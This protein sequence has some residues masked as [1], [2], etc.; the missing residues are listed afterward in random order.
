MK[1]LSLVAKISSAV[2]LFILMLVLA[3]SVPVFRRLE[4]VLDNY[5]QK[6]SQ[7]VTKYS[8]LTISY[9]SISPSIFAYLG[10]KGIKVCD[11]DQRIIGQ[12]KSTHIKYKLIPLLKGDYES[13]VKSITIDGVVL[14]TVPLI[15]FIQAYVVE[16]PP[17]S[18]SE[19]VKKPPALDELFEQLNLLID[20]IPQN[21]TL[22]NFTV[23]YNKDSIN[24]SLLV[25]EIRVLNSERRDYITVSLKSD[26]DAS[27]GAKAS[28]NGALA[29]NGR[30]TRN[31]D[32]S[33]AYIN[34]SNFAF[35]K[36]KFNKFNFLV[37]YAS[38][39]LELH[40][41]QNVIPVDLGADFDFATGQLGLKLV[42]EN[43]SPVSVISNATSQK[44][45]QKFKELSV[46]ARAGLDL[47]INEAG[48]GYYVNGN[49]AVPPSLFPQGAQ[50]VIDLSGNDRRV[51]VRQLSVTG[52]NIDTQLDLSYLIK[53]SQLSGT[54]ALE[55]Y[56]LP[57]KKVVSTEVY[58]DPLDKSG[59]MLFS[60]QIFIG[61]HSL[62][63]LQA[64]VIPQSD[65]ID[66][67]FEV[68]DYSHIDE[69]NQ[70]IIKIDGSYLTQSKYVQSS[71]SL[72]SIYLETIMSL[73]AEILPQKEAEAVQSIVPTVKDFM[74]T[75][76]AYVSTD[77]NSV[78]Y[79]LPYL[80]LANTKK[81]NQLLFLSVNGNEQS[82]QLNRFNL[83]YGAFALDA[84]AS[85]D[86]MPGTQ[87]KF[88]TLDMITSSIPYHFSGT[89]MP[90]II[91]VTG[92]YGTDAQVRLGKNNTLEG[93][94]S[95]TNLPFLINNSTYILSLNTDFDYT[96]EQG[97][98]ITL[99]HLQIEQDDPDTSVNPR[100]ELSGSATKYGAQINDIAYTDLYSSL[101]GNSDITVNI[102]DNILSSAG[103]QMNLRDDI[104]DESLVIDASVSN[105]DMVELTAHNIIN[106]LYVNA[107][108]EASHFSLNRFMSVRNDNNELTASLY[109][110]GTLE[111]PYA[112]ATVEK[113]S[114]LLNDEIVSS[115]GSLIL[116]ERDV[117]INDFIL[118]GLIWKVSDVS[119]NLS[120]SDYT[121]KMTAQFSTVGEKNVVMPM[122]LTIEDSYVPE[123]SAIPENLTAKLSCPNLSGT[124]FKKPMA[125]D[126][127]VNYSKDFISFYSSD[128]VGMYG[129]LSQA[130]GLYVSISCGDILSTEITGSFAKDNQFVKMS[131][132]YVNLKG[133]L[134]NVTLDDLI[135]IDQGILKGSVTMYG[136]FDTPEFK[137]ALSISN[138]VFQLPTV[139]TQRVSTEKILITAANNEFAVAE[140]TYNLKNTPKFK[141]SSHVYMNKWSLDHFD[142]RI[143]SLDKQ[144][145]PV[146]LKIPM[147]TIAGDT[148]C[149]FTVTFENNNL[150]YTGSFFVENLNIESNLT[151]LTNINYDVDWGD[152]TFSTN[153]KLSTGTHA[154]LNFNPLL[155]CVFVPHTSVDCKINT[156]SNLYQLDGSLLLK[157]GDVAYLNRN[158]YI[159]EGS[160]KFN[161]VDIANPQISLRAETREKDTDGNTIRI[162]LSAEN[163]YLLDFNPIFSS[164]PAKSENEI[165][166][167][168]GQIVLADSDSV[169]NLVLS[170]GEYYL[171]STLVRN[172]ENK[173]RDLLNFDIFSVRTNI[174]QNTI[175]LSNQRNKTKELTIGNFFDNSTV[176]IGKYLGSALY[177]DA[178]L[179]MSAS[180]YHDVDYLS[181]NS[182]LFQPEF[183]LELELPVINIRWDMAWRL[184]PGAQLQSFVPATT[185]SL[186]WKFTF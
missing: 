14:D 46:T 84:T 119:G 150:D 39:K 56:V 89:I 186:S 171:Q 163:Q 124:L 183:G 107:M 173:L 47:N 22:K 149:D 174:L 179:N 141:M 63:A 113:M 68:N 116:E 139:F 69:N 38:K 114:F 91:T 45:L 75:G 95:F 109:L 6:F 29:V 57:N 31:L 9:E 80:V 78:S 115:S 42:T 28:T 94:A 177:A 21:I 145:V 132:V 30:L 162:I 144:L 16:Q 11:K 40:T 161:P 110:S 12:V 85:L 135:M 185:V 168:L 147:L 112:T 13:I 176:Y 175:N 73:A 74:F 55:K 62:T 184:T 96:Q 151:D 170:A 165:K 98:Q 88:Y 169:G 32:N 77:F 79:N 92:D 155:R 103:I 131:N 172:M 76:D 146:R 87:D 93:F 164:I 181:A 65:S 100:L 160:I 156:A 125:F 34:L 67:D 167:L 4:K 152:L 58:F 44:D 10:I 122:I 154:S 127:F 64:R 51:D 83:I 25:K 101:R 2:F 60:P 158:F 19:E 5:T 102:T 130:D 70:G 90:E 99:Q 159:K 82:V 37:S 53:T 54:V 17:D 36:Y 35:S 133:L 166:L 134:K 118:K 106:S 137:G 33:Y 26:V 59:F 142:A 49:V 108:I 153:I 72:E 178:M 86:S 18:A 1:K 136:P 182:I 104:S 52:E 8:G 111:H 128:N 105:P 143:A 148:E 120:L 20:Y 43:L 15:D 81:D 121:G 126:L 129:N 66:F 50:A 3:L 117:T 61:E 27:F 123:G 41:V 71:V 48:F 180:N 7:T 24:S 138:P 157:S 97:P 140:A 23:K